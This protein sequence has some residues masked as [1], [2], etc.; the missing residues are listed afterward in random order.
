MES[1]EATLVLLKRKLL[2]L[3]LGDSMGD[4]F[5]SSSSISSCPPVL[6]FLIG[7]AA[8]LTVYLASLLIAEAFSESE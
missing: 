1:P 4:Y 5:F 6:F 8:L 7:I 3:D 2:A